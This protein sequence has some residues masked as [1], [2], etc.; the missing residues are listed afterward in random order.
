MSSSNLNGVWRDTIP[1]TCVNGVWRSSDEWVN[2]N[3]VWRTSSSPSPITE[4]DIT[5]FEVVYTRIMDIKY[6]DFPLLRDNREIPV[7]VEIAGKAPNDGYSTD[8]KSFVMRYTN[9]KPDV[10]GLAVYSGTLCVK[11][12]SGKLIPVSDMYDNGVGYNGD[13]RITIDAYSTYESYGPDVM[14]W[15]RVFSEEDNLPAFHDYADKNTLIMN[16]YPI[17][18]TYERPQ[19]YQHRSLIGIARNMT[20]RYDNMVG[21]HGLLDHTYDT[22]FLNGNPMPFKITVYE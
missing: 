17:L 4:S 21:S 3:G 14:G 20:D 11:L 18:P 19:T 6:F 13:I 5:A 1:S 9:E 15:N 7:V 12:H 2:V 8:P 10:E 16:S 22:I